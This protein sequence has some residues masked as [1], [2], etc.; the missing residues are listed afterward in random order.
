MR[1]RSACRMLVVVAVV[2]AA[3]PA[4]ATYTFKV[5]DFP[6]AANVELY[7]INNKGEV[8][9]SAFDNNFKWITTFVYDSK[10]GTFTTLSSAPLL[11]ESDGF[12]IN[13]GDVVVGPVFNSQGLEGGYIRNKSGQYM[14]FTHPGST[15]FT[16]P[17]GV[18]D[19][20]IV[21]GWGDTSA[22][23]VGFIYDPSKNTFTDIIPS[24]G[25]T[26]AQGINSRGDVVGSTYL[27]D[28][29][30][31]AGS[32]AG[33]YGWM[34][35]KNGAITY[36]RVNGNPTAARGINDWG[37]IAGFTTDPAAGNVGFVATLKGL[38]YEALTVAP[39]D[40]LA[41]PSESATD[42]EAINNL[43]AIVGNAFDSAGVVHGF[44]GTKGK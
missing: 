5:I 31:Y 12:G 7:G 34:R 38:P 32:P 33:T 20:G 11:S 35:S 22:G 19:K 29:G 23:S 25:S 27:P 43:G 26:I 39:G 42:P 41:V 9:G 30:A 3:S 1:D 4:W 6:G 16:E 13:D 18:N 24:T 14:I 10:A 40:L 28:G 17:R 44:I 21:T 2:A 36:F 15:V 8:I 37:V